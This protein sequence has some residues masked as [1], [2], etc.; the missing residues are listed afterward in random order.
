MGKAAQGFLSEAY[1]EYVEGR[2]P[3][4]TQL[5]G[6]RAISGWKLIRR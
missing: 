1:I 4:R 5:S 2:N 3:R 6:K